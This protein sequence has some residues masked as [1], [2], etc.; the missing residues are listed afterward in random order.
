MF[1]YLFSFVASVV[2]GIYSINL[3]Q[4]NRNLNMLHLQ[5]NIGCGI[6]LVLFHVEFDYMQKAYVAYKEETMP[7]AENRVTPRFS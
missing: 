7:L 6:Q 5:C 2:L 4:R 1:A 3:L